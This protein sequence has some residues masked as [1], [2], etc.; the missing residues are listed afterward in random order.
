MVEL[1][2][3]GGLLKGLTKETVKKR[4]YTVTLTTMNT[5]RDKGKGKSSGQGGPLACFCGGENGASRYV[6]ETGGR[7]R[8]QFI[9][10]IVEFPFAESPGLFAWP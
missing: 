3:D 2:I 5:A 9:E 7:E 6:N 4:A 8:V 1:T 10:T